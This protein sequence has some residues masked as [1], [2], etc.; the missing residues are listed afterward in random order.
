MSV[1]DESVNVGESKSTDEWGLLSLKFIGWSAIAF[2]LCL[3]LPAPILVLSAVGGSSIWVL[4]ALPPVLLFG[5]GFLSSV[6]GVLSRRTV[7]GR[8]APKGT[9]WTVLLVSIFLPSLYFSFPVLMRL[10]HG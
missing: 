7:D 1:S 10:A 3:A 9:S 8:K 5:L 4:F 2:A 6:F